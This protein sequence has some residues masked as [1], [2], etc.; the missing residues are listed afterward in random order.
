MN[1][2]RIFQEE[3]G[4]QCYYYTNKVLEFCKQ[5]CGKVFF[6][7]IFFTYSNKATNKPS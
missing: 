3:V 7:I 6:L 2:K 1:K 5:L 4:H